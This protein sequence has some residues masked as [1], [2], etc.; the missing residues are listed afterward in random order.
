[1]D[2]RWLC[3]DC[4]WIA[5]EGDVLKAPHPF[6]K[7]EIIWGCPMCQGLTLTRA[8]DREGCTRRATV[9]TPWTDRYWS[10]C[11]DHAPTAAASAV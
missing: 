4:L 5:K 9:G 11:Y 2:A 1:M 8:C 3:D 10:T 7:G 6:E